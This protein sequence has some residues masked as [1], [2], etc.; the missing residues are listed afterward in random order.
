MDELIAKYADILKNAKVGDHTYSGIL[1]DFAHEILAVNSDV[2][3]IALTK[4]Q[5]MDLVDFVFTLRT[6]EGMASNEGIVFVAPD[7]KKYRAHNVVSDGPDREVTVSLIA[8]D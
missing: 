4:D 7:R 2:E 8:E 5:Y 6:F 3:V 1:A